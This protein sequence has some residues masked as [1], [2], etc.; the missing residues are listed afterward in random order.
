[1]AGEPPVAKRRPI[2]WW[3][4]TRWGLLLTSIGL[5]VLWIPL[6][7]ALGA[8]FL[9][10]G[11]TFLFLGSKA[12]SRKHE[13]SVS[14]AFVLLTVGGVIIGIFFVAFL[15]E[16]LYVAGRGLPLESLLIPAQRLLWDTTW[17]TAAFAAGIALQINYLVAE[18]QRRV[19]YGLCLLLFLTALAATWLSEPELAFLDSSPV[20]S[21]SVIEFLLRLSLWRMLEAPAY[22]GLAAVHMQA[23]WQRVFPTQPAPAPVA[24]P[25]S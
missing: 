14:V 2:R 1:M 15:L 20:R 22:L 13:V 10:F 4:R 17:G 3:R 6:V 21:S 5:I 12:V 16:S 24:D 8:L 19:V 7:A 11:S 25:P 9:S 23:Y 18:R